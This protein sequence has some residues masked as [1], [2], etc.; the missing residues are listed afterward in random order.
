MLYSCADTVTTKY[1]ER[2]QTERCGTQKKKVQAVLAL[3]VLLAL[4]E[5]KKKSTK[6]KLLKAKKS[7]ERWGR[8][9]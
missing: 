5:K 1:T 2:V 9:E 6:Q 3:S 4:S 7:Y 8:G